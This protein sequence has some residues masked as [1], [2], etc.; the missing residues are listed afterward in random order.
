M[1]PSMCYLLSIMMLTIYIYISIMY[2]S[3]LFKDCHLRFRMFSPFV[4]PR[5]RSSAPFFVALAD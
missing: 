2:L 3:K 1:Y 4:I 5:Y